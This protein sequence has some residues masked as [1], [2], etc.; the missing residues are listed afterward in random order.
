MLLERNSTI[1]NVATE[2]A[3]NQMKSR[4]VPLNSPD[5]LLNHN[6]RLQ[7]LP[8]LPLQSFYRL[9][10]RLHLTPGKL[11]IVLPL[12]VSPLSGEN[13]VL[14]IVNYCGYYLD[15]LHIFVIWADGRKVSYWNQ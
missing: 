6:A 8:D 15:L 4:V 10:P 1:L 9:L 3:H 5:K 2:A 13:A 14:L 12:L 7:F 11:S